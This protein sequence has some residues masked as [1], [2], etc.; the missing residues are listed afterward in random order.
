MPTPIKL[1]LLV[2]VALAGFFAKDIAGWFYSSETAN[3]SDYCQL[4]TK[5]CQQ[6]NIIVAMESD[7]AQ[8]LAPVKVVATWPDNQTDSLRLSLHGYEMDMGMALFE[9]KA[10]GEHTFEAEVLLPACRSKNMTWIGQLSDGQQS[11]NVAIRMI[12]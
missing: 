8:P 11:M 12:R 6:G 1:I 5:E 7:T 4:S 2:I 10:S 9:L 3:L